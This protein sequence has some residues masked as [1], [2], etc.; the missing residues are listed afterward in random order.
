[1]KVQVSGAVPP[2]AARANTRD[3]GRCTASRRENCSGQ[4][5]GAHGRVQ[6]EARSTPKGSQNGLSSFPNVTTRLQR[7][8]V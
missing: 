5:Q 7:N 3:T 1:M 6:P 2:K 8:A 4:R